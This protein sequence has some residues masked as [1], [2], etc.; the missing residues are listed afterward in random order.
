MTINMTW[1][2]AATILS[3]FAGLVF[4]YPYVYGGVGQLHAMFSFDFSEA[5]AADLNTARRHQEEDLLFYE[6]R[7]QHILDKIDI[8]T[9]TG[10]DME[11]LARY[12]LKI[13]ELK[14]KL[15]L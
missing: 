5:Q 9:A 10:D 8:N 7:K 15:G 6:K 2:K 13:S 12:E 3:V 14:K 11:D 1:K 4:A